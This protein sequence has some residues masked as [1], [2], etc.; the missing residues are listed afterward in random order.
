MMMV[1]IIRVLMMK[2][3]VVIMIGGDAD[4]IFYLPDIT[5]SM[6]ALQLV[7]IVD[8]SR[9]LYSMLTRR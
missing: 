5:T 3:V 6:L 8:S 7:P 2:M 4:A 1:L 9:L